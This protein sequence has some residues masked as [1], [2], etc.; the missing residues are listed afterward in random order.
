MFPPKNYL[1]YYAG[2]LDAEGYGILIRLMEKFPDMRIQ[3]AL[4]IYRKML[5]CIDQRNDQN[6]RQTQNTNTVIPSSS[7][8][9]KRSKQLLLQ[10]WQENKRIPQE[11]LTI[12]TWR[13]WM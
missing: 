3:P 2:D 8:L 7:G 6:I 1:F 12:E 13:R 5:D 11:V 10:L 9:R 4:K